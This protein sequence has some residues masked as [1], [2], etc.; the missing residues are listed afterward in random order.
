MCLGGP[1][2]RGALT[3]EFFR[4]DWRLR[5]LRHEQL[6]DSQPAQDRH[7]I[8]SAGLFLIRQ[9]GNDKDALAT[10][11]SYQLD[12]RGPSRTVQTACSTFLVVV[13][14][15]CQSLLDSECDIAS[16]A[17]LRS[18]SLTSMAT[19]IVKARS[20]PV[21]DT[22]GRS[23]QPRAGLSFLEEKLRKCLERHPISV[24]RIPVAVS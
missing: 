8:E 7:L 11:V 17:E 20:F 1:R 23:M 3:R 18:R 15:A 21:T 6:L 19:S 14:I 5:R 13:H 12:L 22:V 10:R 16:P 4:F 24:D 2:E 9:T